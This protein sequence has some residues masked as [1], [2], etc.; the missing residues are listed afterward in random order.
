MLHQ[1]GADLCPPFH[2]NYFESRD[3]SATLRQWW[4]EPKIVETVEPKRRVDHLRWWKAQR[5]QS[6]GG[7]FRSVVG[8]KHPLLTLCFENL[9]EA[10]GSQTKFI[11]TRR[12]LDES[13]ASLERLGWWDDPRRIQSTLFEQARDLASDPRVR[14]IDL[15]QTR[16]DPEQTLQALVEHLGMK[17]TNIQME[18]ALRLVNREGS[19]SVHK[20]QNEGAHPSQDSD[21]EEHR[22]SDQRSAIIATILSGNASDL[23]A[24]AI[25]SAQ[26]YVDRFILVDTGITDN[27][28]QIAMDILGESLVVETFS[29]I[30]DFAAA[31]NFCLSVAG[32]HQARWALTLDTDERLQF[33]DFADVQELRTALDDDASVSAYMVMECDGTYSKERLVRLPTSLRWSGRTHETLIGPSLADRR[34]LSGVRFW[35]EKKTSEQMQKKLRRDLEILLTET[36]REPDNGRWWYY[37]GQSYAGLDLAVHAEYAFRRASIHSDWHEQKAFSKYR[38]AKAIADQGRYREALS[39]CASSLAEHP[40]APEIAYLAA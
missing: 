29:W 34:L 22:I 38:M 8:A 37:L 25:R 18:N 16:R 2:G 3:L 31:R 9:L 30:N 20:A 33:D 10:W 23:I 32:K 11:W 13:I 21:S 35:E 27:T 40:S 4:N 26:R 7:A 1:L 28:I 14:V 12:E 39:E 24:E 36:Q 5:L 17:P 15:E 19:S 6:Y